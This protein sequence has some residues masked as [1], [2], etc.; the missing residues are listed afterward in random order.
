[1]P[2]R[3]RHSSAPLVLVFALALH[4]ATA[5]VAAV[6]G[7]PD[8]SFRGTGSL[9]IGSVAYDLYGTDALVAPDGRAV[10]L[11][12][13]YA[14]SSDTKYAWWVI[15]NDAAV[16]PTVCAGSP[17]FGT[18]GHLHAGTF[19]GQGRL[20]VVGE[21]R[22]DSVGVVGIVARFLYPS[23]T[24]DP[25][26][27]GGFVMLDLAG[28]TVAEAVAVDAGGNLA[29]VGY[30]VDA[31]EGEQGFVA[32]ILANGTLP[33]SFDGDGVRTLGYYSGDY[34]DR[35]EAVALAKGNKI[36]VAGWTENTTGDTDMT[37]FK[38]AGD[39]QPDNAF[40][41]NGK[42]RVPFDLEGS[43]KDDRAFAILHE[44]D[45]GRVVVAGNAAHGAS[46][47]VAVA[48]RLLAD[49]S[50]D[51]TFGSG[52]RYVAPPTYHSFDSSTFYDIARPGDGKYVLAG[53]RRTA[54][55]GELEVRRLLSGGAAD[56]S[57]GSG[58]VASASFA[59]G[60]HEAPFG[61][62]LA[63][64]GGKP[65]VGGWVIAGKN[66]LVIARFTNAFVFGDGFEAGDV[67]GWPLV[68]WP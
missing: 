59:G 60:D 32:R 24:V 47:V 14:G 10:V 53:N 65:L 36:W 45:S 25:A 64:Q 23:C 56:A 48:A 26:F 58:G 61:E 63:L 9:S 41:T 44:R 42:M 49:G 34:D 39:G 5:P 35:F 2:R 15:E 57:F 30:H 11:G 46:S 68:P 55:D 62:G 66:D 29:V 13:A 33:S 4:A 67:G 38:L 28:S 31:A 37:V 16:T 17:P 6:D 43:G 19:D 8:G 40:S 22:Y 52:G 21:A 3:R 50:Y 7:L 20:V 18:Y 1:M 54:N 51:D 27:D 12:S